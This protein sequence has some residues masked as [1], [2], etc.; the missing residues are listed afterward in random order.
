[1]LAL[2]SAAAEFAEPDHDLIEKHAAF[3]AAVEEVI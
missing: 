3:A 1:M 2:L